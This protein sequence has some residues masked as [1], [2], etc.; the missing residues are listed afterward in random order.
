MRKLVLDIETIPLVSAMSADYPFE[1]RQPPANYKTD[2]AIAK[3]RAMDVKKWESE[4]VKEC[5]LNPR[6]GRIV[7]IGMTSDDV[8]AVASY[9]AVTEADEANVLRAFWAVVASHGGQVITWNG[10][11]DLQFILLRSIANNIEPSV[12]PTIVREWFRKYSVAPHFDC[13]AVITQWAPPK[14]GEGLNQ[15]AA[16]FGTSGKADGV[17]GADV[18][19]MFDR[20][21]YD[22]IRE[23]CEQDV[24]ATREIYNKMAPHFLDGPLTDG[25]M[26]WEGYNDA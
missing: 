9:I 23:Y 6:L 11:W 12:S 17:S 5:S 14:A 21:E 13:K 3:W 15:W 25:S 1:D 26:G 10:S 18:Y 24:R 4:R 7:C 16:F 22:A 20:G 19:A 2:E 8:D